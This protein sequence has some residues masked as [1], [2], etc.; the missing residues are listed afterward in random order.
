MRK[1]AHSRSDPS[2]PHLVATIAT[3]GPDTTLATKLVAFVID[4]TGGD[5]TI[6]TRTWTTQAV[7]VRN[8]P[9]IA[10]D[11]A[12]FLHDHGVTE[13]IR[14]DRM[15]G[16]PHE[17]GID[18]PVG[19]SCPRCP[20]WAGIDRFTHEP[21]TVAAPTMSPSEILTAL[22]T[23]AASSVHPH[24]ALASAD[25]HREALVEPLLSA[26]D[27]GIA[28]PAD[29]PAEDATLFSYAL[30][31]FAKWRETRAFS[32]VVDWLSPAEEQPFLIAGDVVAGWLANPRGGVRRRPGT[33][34]SAHPES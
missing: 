25:G 22:A 13:T 21:I 11:V 2:G 16:C 28:N 24:D 7:D 23:A 12:A 31:L 15:I 3:Y 9:T 1:R 5:E 6:A 30:Y 34:Q 20:F 8:D 14:P 32:R 17:E 10:A 19:R 18:Y 4:Q 33:D 29:A 26:L 27:R